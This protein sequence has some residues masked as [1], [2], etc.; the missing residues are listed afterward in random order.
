MEKISQKYP[1]ISFLPKW[2]IK[3]DA[4]YELGQCNSIIRALRDIPI[5]PVYRGMLLSVSLI[6][7]A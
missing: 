4:M 7:G 2:E 3:E 5:R 6:N 1:H